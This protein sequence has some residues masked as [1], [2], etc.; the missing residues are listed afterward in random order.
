MRRSS[1]TSFEDWP[2]PIHTLILGTQ[3][4][5]QGIGQSYAHEQNTFWWIAGDCLQFRRSKG[6]SD[7]TNIEF[8]VCRHLRYNNVLTYEEQ[9]LRLISK[10]FALCDVLASDKTP[11]DIRGVCQSHPSIRRIILETGGAGCSAF[12]KHN[13]DWW[14]EDSPES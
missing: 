14:R 10:G 3:H 4:K 11:N 9:L 6:I 13:K 1:M 2:T 5:N 8:A 12:Y 7:K